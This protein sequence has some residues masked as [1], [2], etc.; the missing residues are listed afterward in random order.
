MNNQIKQALENLKMM[1]REY[2][3]KNYGQVAPQVNCDLIEDF[4]YKGD[5]GM[6][7]ENKNLHLEFTYKLTQQILP[8]EEIRLNTEQDI[9]EFKRLIEQD[10]NDIFC[11]GD[12]RA[13]CG[14][15]TNFNVKVR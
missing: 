1:E 15:I 9:E 11:V 13:E 4:I 10:I 2:N 6:N 14:R 8:G 7:K 3:F 12:R 5:I